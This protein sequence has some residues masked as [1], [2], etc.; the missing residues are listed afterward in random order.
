MGFRG[1]DVAESGCNTDQNLFFL[2][3][4][5]MALTLSSGL[6]QLKKNIVPCSTSFLIFGYK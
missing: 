6:N 3:M 4:P 1:A 2:S 5:H